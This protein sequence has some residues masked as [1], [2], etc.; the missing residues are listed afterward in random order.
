MN[1]RPLIVAALAAGVLAVSTLSAAPGF[2]QAATQADFL[3]GEV[4]Q[5]TVDEHGRLTLGPELTRVYDAGVPFVWT[6]L[7]GADG[8]LFLG[9]GNDGKVIRVDR[10]GQ[11][12]VFY[13]ST[14]MEVHALPP[15]WF[16]HYRDRLAAVT[17]D[18]VVRVAREQIHPD[19]AAIVIVGNAEEV[20]PQL[21]GLGMTI[22]RA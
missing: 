2:W 21:E 12:T 6:M 22:E 15:E 18:V 4:D 5:L 19:R 13:D 17:A 10:N 11:G 20:E 9:T 7:S 8:A 3:R 16:D 1:R 14:E